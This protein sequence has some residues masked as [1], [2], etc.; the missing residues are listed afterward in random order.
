M[1]M[2][3]KGQTLKPET[4][5]TPSTWVE[6]SKSSGVVADLTGLTIP[7]DLSVDKEIVLGVH[8]KPNTKY[9]LLYVL[10]SNSLASCSSRLYSLTD[11]AVYL[12]DSASP[13]GNRKNTFTTSASL[14]S[15]GNFRWRVNSGGSG[16]IKIKDIRVF[17]LPSGSEIETDFTNLTADQLAIKYPFITGDICS[18]QALMARGIGKNLT[19]NDVSSFVA[20]DQSSYSHNV[21]FNPN[22]TIT[23][24]PTGSV[25]TYAHLVQRINGSDNKLI[26]QNSLRVFPSTSYKLCLYFDSADNGKVISTLILRQSDDFTSTVGTAT[27][28]TEISKTVT[29]GKIVYNMTTPIDVKKYI[30]LQPRCNASLTLTHIALFRSDVI[31]TTFEAH[32]ET[33]AISPI[34]LRRIGT[35]AD[36]FDPV[37]GVLS[38]RIGD[39]ANLPGNLNWAHH[40]NY[41]GYKAASV[42]NF[43]TSLGGIPNA[44]SAAKAGEVYRYDNYLANWGAASDGA[45]NF[46]FV[47]GT[48][49]LTVPNSE[50]GFSEDMVPISNEWKAYFYGWRMCNPDGSVPWDGIQTKSWKKITDGT[51]ITSVLP[52]AS[53]TGYLPYR[54][55]CQLVNPIITHFQP[56]PLFAQLYGV[57]IIEPVIRDCKK[58]VAGTG[59]ITVTDASAPIDSIR[60]VERV[61]MLGGLVR[62]VDVTS[63]CTITDSGTTL[64]I[65]GFDPTKQYVYECGIT[66][67]YSCLPTI[68]YQY[69]QADYVKFDT[70][71]HD[72][73]AAAADWTLSDAEQKCLLLTLTNA[74]AAVN[75]IAKDLEGWPHAVRNLSGQ[76]A[77]I[78]KSGGTGVV[79]AAGKTAWVIHNGTDYV[80]LTADA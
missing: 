59:K 67:W 4:P 76:A 41:S 24:N 47:N 33:F 21:T 38:K 43:I 73:Q 46:N 36:I 68:D 63:S 61:D 69:P 57:L 16:E 7:A 42:A 13:L 23:L 37:T 27:A 28:G 10:V 18:V 60:K 5:Y 25:G 17:E 51:G 74:G 64:T 80:R 72:Y 56:Q 22:G 75:I 79:I 78:K 1:Q 62:Y 53:Y 20:P 40:N 54:V 2:L 12:I 30:G 66:S 8:M 19:K 45:Y 39:P 3:I 32:A 55:F 31:D 35:V 15:N 29:D 48:F 49:Y 70:A 9:G 6:W 26:R 14:S 77:T 71:S 34:I 58:P 44:Y 11:S 52:T 65:T 50:T